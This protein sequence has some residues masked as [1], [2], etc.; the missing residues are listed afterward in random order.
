MIAQVRYVGIVCWFV[1]VCVYVCVCVCVCVF[2]RARARVYVRVCAFVFD[3]TWNMSAKNCWIHLMFTSDAKET[4][5]KR[6]VDTCTHAGP[7]TERCCN[8]QHLKRSAMRMERDAKQKKPTYL[9]FVYVSALWFHSAMRHLFHMLC[10]YSG[11][12]P[13]PQPI[14]AYEWKQKCQKSW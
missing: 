3:F 12:E 2:A 7:C 10:S 6:L 8:Q 4:A 14:P 5:R 13:G 11:R 1:C 9:A